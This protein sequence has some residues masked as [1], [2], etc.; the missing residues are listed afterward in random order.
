MPVAST[1]EAWPELAVHL[2]GSEDRPQVPA[3]VLSFEGDPRSPA[4]VLAA[5]RQRQLGHFAILAQNAA[6]TVLHVQTE[7][8]V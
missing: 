6:N 2:V 8:L 1:S 3:A 4:A 5:Q 7:Q